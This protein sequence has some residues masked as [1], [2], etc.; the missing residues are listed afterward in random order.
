VSPLRREWLARIS[1]ELARELASEEQAGRERGGR[2]RGEAPAPEP[3][4]GKRDFTANIK[5]GREV[6]QIETERG[7]KKTVLLPYERIRPLAAQQLPPSSGYQKLKGKVLYRE[8]ELLG[9][10]RL[11]TILRLLPRIELERG[12]LER[13]DEAP[14]ALDALPADFAGRLG[15]LLR[16]CRLKKRT[17]KLGFLALNTDGHGGFWF[18]G[19]RNYLS[20]MRE[21]LFSLES[22]ADAPQVPD[23]EQI[24]ALYRTLSRELEQL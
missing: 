6:F 5:I 10:M 24:N 21:S 15:E 3:P 4:R 13:P 12:I 20:A 9:G 17:R 8:F 2:G 11:A 22:L 16:P 19:S 18:K 1:P 7:R 14:F 23:R